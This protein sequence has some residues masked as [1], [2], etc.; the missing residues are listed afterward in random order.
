MCS[1]APP[2][3]SKK[4]KNAADIDALTILHVTSPGKHEWVTRVCRSY[5]HIDMAIFLFKYISR[6]CSNASVL[7][8]F[9]FSF[10]S[11]TYMYFRWG[12]L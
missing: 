12:S 8:K 5:Q 10:N 6:I 9:S 4:I 3:T 11:E 7:K 1:Y 2:K